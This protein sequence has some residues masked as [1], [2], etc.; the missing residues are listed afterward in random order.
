MSWFR[1]LWR[2]RGATSDEDRLAAGSAAD[3][4]FERRDPLKMDLGRYKTFWLTDFAVDHPVSIL[5]LIVLIVLGGLYS[6][7][8]VPKEASPDVTVPFVAVNTI[9][10]GVAPEDIETLITRP[11]EEELN[12]IS[13]IKTLTSQSVESF[14]S[15][16]AEF[17]AGM[18]MTEALQ[19][20]REKVDIAKPEIPEA[21][22]EPAAA[23]VTPSTGK[24]LRVQM[25]A[26]EKRL[27]LEALEAAHW[28]RGKTAAALKLNYK[29]LQ[30]KMKALGIK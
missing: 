14:S 1:R 2:R 29:T 3:R 9:Y 28:H 24:G 11:L 15:I 8:T 26:V 12:R 30:R 18:D 7:L 10:S 27:I 21:A 16:T 5:T 25:A 17:E 20:V 23:S 6:Y 13:D 4:L 22:E 19:L